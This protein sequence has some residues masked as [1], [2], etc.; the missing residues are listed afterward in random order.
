MQNAVIYARYS[1][2]SQREE[3]IE[4]QLRECHDFAKRNGFRIIEEYCDR[5]LTGK[6][7]NRAGFQKM[8][9]DAKNSKFEC[10][11]VYK[12]DRF[13]RNRYDSAMYKNMLKKHNV[14]VISVK[15]NISDSPEGIILESVLEGMAEY[16][17]ANLSQNIK[18]GM[19]ENAMQCKFNG[20]GLPLGYKVSADQ[21]YEV[22]P[23]E[24][25][26]VQEI[27]QMY[28]DGNS[29]SQ[30]I[31]YCN[32]K[33]YKTKR[34]APFNKNSL[35]KMLQNDKYIGVYR[36]SGIVVE[37]GVPAILDKVLFDKVQATFKRNYT[38]R[39]RSK[40][41]VDYLLSSKL[42]CGECGANMIG[43][44]GTGRHGTK[45]FY[46]KCNG[47]IAKNGCH[48][49]TEQKDWIEKTVVKITVDKV[50]TDENI[51]VIAEKAVELINKEAADMT[52]LLH[53]ESELKE[54]KKR[55]KNILDLME[56]GIATSSTKDRLLELEAYAAGLQDNI[57]YEKIKK[58][59][60]SKEHIIFWLNS[61]KNGDINDIEYCR[62]VID[63][64]V[65]RV[66]VYDTDDGN[67]RKIV[68]AFNTTQN[69]TAEVS[70]ADFKGES[71]FAFSVKHLLQFEPPS[72]SN[73]NRCFVFSFIYKVLQSFLVFAQ[74]GQKTITD[75]N[76]EANIKKQ[77][78]RTP[79]SVL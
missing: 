8:I 67:G 42:F 9:K 36:H 71:G 66:Y 78:F 17:S 77:C 72:G 52:L 26:I 75:E 24:A 69:S 31:E 40:A 55:I 4:G 25:K 73:S 20:S 1:S 35:R 34:G 62:R 57:E 23:A 45:H 30:V 46:Y 65:N 13:A 43:N 16:Y 6:T 3:S 51:D 14:K 11:L 22:D 64:L 60:L 59:S 47:R 74:T 32:G 70:F 53:Y 56:E 21:K 27:F 2:H 38:S 18:R 48:K 5:A 12:L 7:D 68:I 61:F 63:T 79:M 58:P 33:G 15:E 19:L 39:A 10:V 76:G 37:N 50:L 54:T 28:A 41:I 49:H 44:S 29:A